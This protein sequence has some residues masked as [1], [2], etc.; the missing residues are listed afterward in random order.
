MRAR[1][2]IG[3]NVRMQQAMLAYASDMAFM[4]TA[5]RVHGLIWTSPGLQSAS[6]DHAMWFHHASDF[7]GWHL[8]DQDS[9]ATSQG[10]GLVR[11]QMFAQD[12]RLVASV[13]QECLMRVRGSTRA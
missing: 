4:E 1:E 11:G 2:T 6:L 13:A 3:D 12:G 10:R 9:P 5:L 8:F 7:N